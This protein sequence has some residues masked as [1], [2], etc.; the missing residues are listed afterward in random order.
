MANPLTPWLTR[1]WLSHCNQHGTALPRQPSLDKKRLRLITVRS[2]SPSPL[3]SLDYSL[4]RTTRTQA[5]GISHDPGDPL[6]WCEMTDGE[7]WIDCCVPTS[8]VDAF[9]AC[10]PSFAPLVVPLRVP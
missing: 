2:P 5:T 9:N 8:V 4:T 3:A 6:L 10:A 1:E 7:C